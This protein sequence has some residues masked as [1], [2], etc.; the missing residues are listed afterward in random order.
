M[1]GVPTPLPARPDP[2]TSLGIQLDKYGKVGPL[3][4]LEKGSD[5]RRIEAFD[6]ESGF[7]G[8]AV[9]RHSRDL[10]LRARNGLM[11]CSKQ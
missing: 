8:A 1:N 5:K 11:H 3:L 6:D 9:T 2:E 4:R 7:L 10:T